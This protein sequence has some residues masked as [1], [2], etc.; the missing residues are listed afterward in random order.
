MS[1]MA[2]DMRPIGRGGETVTT[3]QAV[4]GDTHPRGRG[5]R[6]LSR[7]ARTHASDESYSPRHRMDGETEGLP[8]AID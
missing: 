3:L 5:F 4:P 1:A 8:A 7:I 6:V 2:M